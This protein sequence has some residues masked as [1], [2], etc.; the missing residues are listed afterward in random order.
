MPHATC[1]AGAVATGS[2]CATE[3]S[4]L[5]ARAPCS[6]SATRPLPV[7][8]YT[9]MVVCVCSATVTQRTA[10]LSRAEHCSLSGLL[11]CLNL[12]GEPC[13][14]W[15]P[16]AGHDACACLQGRVD[17]H[18]SWRCDSYESSAA[19]MLCTARA[20]ITEKKPAGPLHAC[21]GCAQQM[22]P[23]PAL[24]EAHL[25]RADLACSETADKRRSTFRRLWTEERGA[26]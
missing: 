25:P 15:Q 7:T 23:M 2:A 8:P 9:L 17:L 12:Q 11:P 6:Q 14:G 19:C 4:A 1:K 18:A 26:R 20:S 24:P 22:P 16:C 5:D 13:A 10:L 21:P 3:W